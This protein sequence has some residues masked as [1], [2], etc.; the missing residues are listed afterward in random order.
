MHSIIPNKKP[1]I[2]L[3]FSRYFNILFTLRRSVQ[4]EKYI[5]RYIFI[6]H[7]MDFV[8]QSRLLKSTDYLHLGKSYLTK[9]YCNFI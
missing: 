8:S 7:C 1:T 5:Y 6:V 4:L 2:K 9:F 3:F